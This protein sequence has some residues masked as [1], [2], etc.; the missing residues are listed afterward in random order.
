MI[1]VYLIWSIQNE[2]HIQK[3][4]LNKIKDTN[5]PDEIPLRWQDKGYRIRW[6]NTYVHII[7]CICSHDQ[8]YRNTKLNINDVIKTMSSNVN[9]DQG[10][11]ITQLKL[12]KSPNQMHDMFKCVSEKRHNTRR[13]L[14]ESKTNNMDAY[15]F[16][17]KRK[18]SRFQ[19]MEAW[20]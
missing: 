15:D 7:R 4:M 12:L 2:A 3:Q 13:W 5:S 18:T 14:H 10:H 17:F 8:G 1:F 19:M 6:R 16:Q 9:Y 20:V 11:G